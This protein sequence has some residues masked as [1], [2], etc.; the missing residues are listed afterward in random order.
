[1]PSKKRS[2]EDNFWIIWPLNFLKQLELAE[3][4]RNK[5]GFRFQA[6]RFLS[7]FVH[8]A[9]HSWMIILHVW[10]R[11]WLYLTPRFYREGHFFT[12][13]V[14]AWVGWVVDH[15]GHERWIMSLADGQNIAPIYTYE[16]R[17]YYVHILY[18]YIDQISHLLHT[19]LEPSQLVS[20]ILS[21]RSMN[22]MWWSDPWF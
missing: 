13:P 19:V 12:R 22:V 1:M 11:V 14:A 20:W 9:D 15:F 2:E 5:K 6:I 17:T 4:L 18:I 8:Q 3:I 10:N 21:S 16:L 7:Y